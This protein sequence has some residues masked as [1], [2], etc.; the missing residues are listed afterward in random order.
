MIG[1]RLRKQ[2]KLGL[3]SGKLHLVL[4]AIDQRKVKKMLELVDVIGQK[5][6]VVCLPNRSNLTS[7]YQSPKATLLSS[8]K[9]FIVINF[10]M[11]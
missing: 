2:E 6:C 5:G 7:C 9:L 11:F 8:H 3:A 10:I 4:P 1:L